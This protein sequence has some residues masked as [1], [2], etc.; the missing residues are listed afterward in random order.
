MPAHLAPQADAAIVRHRKRQWVPEIE[1]GKDGWHS[2]FAR[3][4]DDRWWALLFE[5]FG[6]RQTAVVNMFFEQLGALCGATWRAEWEQWTANEAELRSLFAIVQSLKPRN[7]AEAAY[8]AQLA[9]LHF[10][11]M[12]LARGANRYQDGDT[13]TT[14]I[15]NKTV[16]AY[17]DGLLIMQRL[18]GKG[19]K[20]VQVI[21]V[22]THRHDHRHVHVDGGSTESGG[23]PHTKPTD[24]VTGLRALP[25]E[26]P[27]GT[28][29]PISGREGQ[30]R[31]PN[32]RRDKGQRGSDG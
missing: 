15:L 32:A 12:K 30:A 2:P 26:S 4:D 8:A 29:M 1:Q 23:Q 10:T 13:R 31:L 7:E 18:K 24:S 3:Q 6:T 21:K 9:A 20:T 14:A 25:S 28:I 11:A 17:G 27:D 19:R 22:E 5:I 16:R